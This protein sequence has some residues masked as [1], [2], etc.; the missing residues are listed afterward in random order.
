MTDLDRIA[1]ASA[2]LVDPEGADF[3][4]HAT[5]WSVGGGGWITSWDPE[6]PVPASLRLLLATE[7]SVHEIGD[8][9]QDGEIVGFTSSATA[10]ID[11]I[12][13]TSDELHKRQ[14]LTAVGYP[15]V[16]DHPAFALSRSSLDC[17]RYFPYLC[18]WTIEGHLALF[19]VDAGYLTGGSYRGMRGGPVFAA[20]GSV[21]G[22]LASGDAG[23]P[24][25]SRFLRIAASS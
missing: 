2:I 12:L 19:S 10:D 9:E 13:S 24:P 17:E 7:G 25:L 1:A 6:V 23:A 16:I 3:V 4:H 21:V 11:L 22:I 15:S 5:A 14:R 20:D 18:P 8:W